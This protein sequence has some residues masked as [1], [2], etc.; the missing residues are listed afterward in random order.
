MYPGIC[1]CLIFDE[2]GKNALLI[3]IEYMI[4]GGIFD[5]LDDDGKKLWHSHVFEDKSGMLV[6]PA[7]RTGSHHDWEQLETKE[8][9]QDV[10]LYGKVGS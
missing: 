4:T 9:E 6:M 5:A 1:Q 3:G 10:K 7:P 2:H 8:M